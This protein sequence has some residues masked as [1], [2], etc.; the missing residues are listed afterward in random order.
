MSICGKYA[1]YLRLY[2]SACILMAENWD[3]CQ[4]LVEYIEFLEVFILRDN[5]VDPLCHLLQVLSSK[6]LL[7][8]VSAKF[9]A[10]KCGTNSLIPCQKEAIRRM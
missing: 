9:R 2:N 8:F 7:D 3:V 1:S 5:G 6:R 10:S 4:Q